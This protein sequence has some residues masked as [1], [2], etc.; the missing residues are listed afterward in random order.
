MPNPTKVRRSVVATV[1][2]VLPQMGLAYATDHDDRQWGITRCTTRASSSSCCSRCLA[3]LRQTSDVTEGSLAAAVYHFITSV[4]LPDAG[5][6]RGL[7]CACADIA[8]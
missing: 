7:R 8:D 4:E 5:W 2:E 1:Q 6:R 3:A